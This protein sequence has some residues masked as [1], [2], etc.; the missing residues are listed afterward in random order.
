MDKQNNMREQ[1]E[2]LETKLSYFVSE[3]SDIKNKRIGLSKQISDYKSL[4]QMVQIF[5][6]TLQEEKILP[7]LTESAARFIGRGSWKIRRNMQ[8]DLFAKYIK[9]QK[10]PLMISDLSK[11]TRFSI[12]KPKF[13]SMIAI[14]LEIENDM[15]GMLEGTSPQP[16]IFSEADLRLLSI[17]GGIAS[18]A[19]NNV[20]L[21]K[22][23]QELAITDGLTGLYVQRY[24]KERLDEEIQRSNRHQLQLSVALIDIDHFKDINDT[25]GHMAG[26]AV[27]RQLSDLLRHRFR[28]TDFLCRYGGEEFAVMM[29]QTDIREAFKVCESIRKAVETEKFFLPVESFKPVQ[30]RITV[31]VGVA[32][33]AEKIEGNK[34]LLSLSDEALYRAK[35]DGR[36]KVVI[37][38]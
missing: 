26:D 8:G 37:S 17:L 3:M 1:E 22:R 9:R 29:M 25:Y 33:L 10:L 11:D 2:V 19:L 18:L 15:W 16:E 12:E 30:A 6:T 24:F 28:E 36:N 27:L 34:E 35:S 32:K 38:A 4:G 7:L 13:Q 31:S 14:P 5:C 23:T 20:F 21:Y